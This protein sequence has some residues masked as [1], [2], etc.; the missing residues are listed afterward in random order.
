[1]LAQLQVI[2]IQLSKEQLA[3]LVDTGE[4]VDSG[5]SAFTVITNALFQSDGIDLSD[6]DCDEVPTAQASFMANLSSCDSK[7]LFEDTNSSTPNDLLVLSLVEQMTDHVANSDK[8]NLT[9][10]MV[11]ESLTAELERYEERV[12]IFKQRLDVDLNE[13]EKLIDSQ[14]DD[15]IRNRNTKFM[16]FQWEINTLKQNL[17][18]HVK[19]KEYLST[20]LIVFKTESK[21]KESKYLNKEIFFYD[22][23]HKQ[24][25][26]YQNPFHL[27]K[28]QRIKPTLYDGSVIAKEHAVISVI[29]DE[30]TLILEEESRSKMLDK[31]NDPISYK[32][33]FNAFDKTLLDEI[34][35]VQTVFNL[36]EAVV[37]QCSVDK[38]IVEIEK[39]E[40]KLENELE[41]ARI[42]RSS[43]NA[44]AYACMYTEQI[45]ELL[46]YVSDTCPN[47][48]LKS[49]K[50][51]AVTPMNKARK[52]TFEK[53][54]A[55]S[56]NN[57]QKR[58]DLH[59]THT[60]N[61]PLVPSTSV[62][63]STNA[64]G[65]IPR[66]QASLLNDIWH[67][68]TTLQALLL[69]EKKSV[70]FSAL[71]LQ[72]KRNLL[73]YEQNGYSGKGQ[74]RSQNNKTEHENG[75]SVKQKLKSKPKVKVKVKK[76]TKVKPEKSKVKD[77]DETEEILNGPPVPI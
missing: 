6:S 36:M 27:K 13:R 72:K 70:R 29:E 62:K 39:K 5:P 33:T 67:L 75:K 16:A 24:A 61:K 44:L 63:S 51:V 38:N 43:D 2:G 69:I 66:I 42:T 32:D 60:T 26:G 15:L 50:L 71:Y 64:S 25:L 57:I 4:R 58:V 45:Q 18:N 59:K 77:E 74:K 56:E 28:A 17:S 35:N 22:D 52:G 11:N 21:E 73:G 76:S 20:T 1:M 68:H 7:V 9:N 53:T 12:A 46:V 31:Q 37:D 3:I 40:L 48:P 14:M 47:S 41:Q 65:S 49:E 30:E 54:N 23:T 34:T 10:K 55:T 19:E 8:E